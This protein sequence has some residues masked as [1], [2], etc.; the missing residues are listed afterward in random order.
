MADFKNT[1]ISGSLQLPSGTTAQRPANPPEGSARYN[2]DLGYVECY[3]N[4]AWTDLTAG[5]GQGI[6]SGAELIL[7]TDDANSY[8]GSGN[9]WFD[10]SGNGN[11]FR[12]DATRAATNY[13]NVGMDFSARNTMAKYKTNSTDVPNLSGDVTIAIVSRIIN[14]TA[15]W[16]TLCRSWNADHQVIIQSGAWDIGMYDNNAV[17]FIDSG[18]D[19][20]QLG[21]Y[22]DNY[23]AM[24]WRWS[25]SDVYTYRFNEG[26]CA[27]GLYTGSFTNSN[28]R[29]NN[30]FSCIGGYHN[31]SND[32]N[33]GSQHWGWI[34]YFAAWNRTL[35]DDETQKTIAALRQRFQ[36]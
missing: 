18:I 15:E 11:D 6:P 32:V 8:P 22:P 13:Q 9:T 23:M 17:G 20:T 3:I 36:C 29:W 35:T 30:S 26:T 5:T 1:L 24:V 28:G 10:V 14:S 12:I 34:K 33:T 4:K 27:S 16:R 2:T 19:Q 21:G 25:D 7:A 31:G